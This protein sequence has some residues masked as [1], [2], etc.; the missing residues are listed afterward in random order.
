M[1]DHAKI[2]LELGGTYVQL[3]DGGG[4]AQVEAGKDFWARLSGRASSPKAAWSGPQVR[5]SANWEMHRQADEV[6]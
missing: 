2:V 3:K 4:T 6:V 5:G 1:A